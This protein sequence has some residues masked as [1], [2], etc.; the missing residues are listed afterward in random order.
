MNVIGARP[1]GWWRDRPAAMRRLVG[2]LRAL[3]AAGDEVAVVFDGRPTDVS[4]PGVDVH[5]ATRCGP[6]AA[7]TD[8][9]ALVAADPRPTSVTVVTS[10]AALA[11]I[12][13]ASGARV[14][15]AGAF[16]RILDAQEPA[17]ARRSEDR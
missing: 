14:I 2:E 7:D 9:A 15:G 6:N 8:I 12:V 5:F 3:A 16:R 11:S 13:R 17:A 4:A 10:D 1:D